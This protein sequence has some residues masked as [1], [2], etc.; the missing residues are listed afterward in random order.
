MFTPF[1]LSLSKY[2]EN[3]T[4]ADYPRR[5]LISSIDDLKEAV[6]SDH[7]AAQMK[8]DH[9]AK[10]NF[11]NADVLIFDL[12]NSHSEDSDAWKTLKDIEEAFPDVEFYAIRSR[13]Y[14]K[15]KKKTKR[16]GEEIFF[17][18]RE[19]WH[20]YFPLG[21]EIANEDRYQELLLKVLGLF[22][23]LDGAA[24]DSAHFFFGVAEPFAEVID[25][26]D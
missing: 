22:P 23:F 15:V 3:A 4:N 6:R 7:I 9:R 8:N 25:S 21:V 12:D 26:D 11:L 1:H 5:V 17:E 18:P 20:L 19:K 24:I 2:R 16:S 10:G 13:N 14:M